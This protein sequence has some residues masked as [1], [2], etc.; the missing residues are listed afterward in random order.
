[1]L[2]LWNHLVIDNPMSLE[3]VRVGRRF[4]RT[5]GDTGKAV[6]YTVI[7]IL[8]VLYVWLLLTILRYREDMS[9]MLLMFELII[10]TL[11]VPASLYGAVSAEREKLTWD[12]LIMTRLTPT[13]IIAGKLGW[14]VLL[15]VGV[16]ALFQ[17]P[18]LVCHF[19]AGMFSSAPTMS[20]PNVEMALGKITAAQSMIFGWSLFL[21]SLSFFASTK[22]RRPITTL[23]ILTVGLLAFLALIPL[24]VSVFGGNAEWHGND[25][26]PLTVVGSLLVHLN[27]YYQMAA[28]LAP[29][30]AQDDLWRAVGL[31]GAMPVVYGIG[32]VVLLIASRQTLRG[33]EA[34]RRNLG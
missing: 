6:N 4:L 20:T 27:P 24:L 3:A 10:L 32:A 19:A 25:F 18:I 26:A 12:S 22:S 14:R 13:Q 29:N 1:M 5:G 15:I 2:S 28:L 9:T 7:G 8:G 17:I 16:M 21:A 31:N 23:S 34:P 11:A 30:S 33:L